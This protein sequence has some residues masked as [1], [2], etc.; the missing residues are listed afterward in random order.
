MAEQECS[1][2][3][4]AGGPNLASSMVQ[5]PHG[6]IKLETSLDELFHDSLLLTRTNRWF[7]HG[8]NKSELVF[9]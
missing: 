9:E 6:S 2:A 7:V 5:I 3:H 1:R 4:D 8:L